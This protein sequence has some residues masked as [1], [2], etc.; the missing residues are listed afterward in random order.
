MAIR[1]EYRAPAT[2]KMNIFVTVVDGFQ[3]LNMVTKSSIL[4]IAGVLDLPLAILLQVC[5]LP[6]FW[7]INLVI[8]EITQM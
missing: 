3:L 2:S 8:L 5:K 1:S 6:D 7:D 4:N